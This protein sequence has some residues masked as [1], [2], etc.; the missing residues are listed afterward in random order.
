MICIK[1][2][3]SYTNFNGYSIVLKYPC[4]LIIVSVLGN[5]QMTRSKEIASRVVLLS[6]HAKHD[7]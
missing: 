7:K 3:L 4:F 1:K 5:R 2:Y 6:V